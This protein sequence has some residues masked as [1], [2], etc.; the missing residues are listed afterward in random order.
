[1]LEL[2][3]FFVLIFP[4]PPGFPL[5]TVVPAVVTVAVVSSVSRSASLPL[6]MINGS[7]SEEFLLLTL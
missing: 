4:L 2:L 7:D 1:L 3:G 5:V 6:G